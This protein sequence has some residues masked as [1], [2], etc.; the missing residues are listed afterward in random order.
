MLKWIILALILGI[1]IWI[2]D[3]LIKYVKKREK[4]P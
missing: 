4:K 3:L 2:L 1:A